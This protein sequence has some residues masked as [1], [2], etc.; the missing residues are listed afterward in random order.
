MVLGPGV[1]SYVSVYRMLAPT[2]PVPIAVESKDVTL[3]SS[4]IAS[5]WRRTSVS[6]SG[7]TR[8]GSPTSGGVDFD[9]VSASWVGRATGVPVGG[10]DRTVRVERGRELIGRRR[11]EDDAVGTGGELVL[12]PLRDVRGR[13]DR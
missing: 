4:P 5:P 7:V 13:T 9:I 8:S 2:W 6:H 3:L 10:A 11:V 12:D 1:P